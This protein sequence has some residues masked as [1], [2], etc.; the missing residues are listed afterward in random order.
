MKTLKNCIKLSCQVKVYIPSTINVKESV[1]SSEWID[2][3]L[4]LLSNEFGGATSTSALGAWVSNQGELVKE[5]VT[6]VFAYANQDKLE[7]SINKIYDFCL[8]MKQALSQE[9]KW[10]ARKSR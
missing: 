5:G 8:S 4:E 10:T 6:V 2:K 1:D 7:W 9:A 3:A